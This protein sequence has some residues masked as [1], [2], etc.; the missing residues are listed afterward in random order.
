LAHPPSTAT[1]TTTTKKET[2]MYTTQVGEL[3]ADVDALIRKHEN[4]DLT[5]T[6]IVRQLATEA[7]VLI[8]GD[9]GHIHLLQVLQLAVEIAVDWPQTVDEKPERDNPYAERREAFERLQR[10]VVIARD[11][12]L[13][14]LPEDRVAAELVSQ[15]QVALQ[16]GDDPVPTCYRHAFDLMKQAISALE[17]VREE[18]AA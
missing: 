14:R 1:G 6:E 15:A 18:R 4:R 10:Q 9:E 17:Q 11:A 2:N 3:S 5:R 13:D 8:Q 16:P 12:A 7:C